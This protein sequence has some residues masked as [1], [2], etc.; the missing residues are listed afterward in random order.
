MH[1]ATLGSPARRFS[2]EALTRFREYDWP[3]NVREIENVVKNALVFAQDE[4][5]RLEDLPEALSEEKRGRGALSVEAAVRDI[6]EAEDWSEE[7]PLIP[8]VELLLVHETVRRLGALR[9]VP[10]Q[11][12]RE[13]RAAVF[14][15]LTPFH[16]GGN[17]L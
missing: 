13:L 17:P 12:E 2:K 11:R 8:R 7:R 10:R 16:R 5:I 14:V 15:P 1:G 6:V 3:G 9:R 4:V